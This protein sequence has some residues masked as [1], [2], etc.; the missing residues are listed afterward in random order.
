M[1]PVTR[2]SAKLHQC[3]TTPPRSR[4]LHIKRRAVF[5]FSRNRLRS[6]SSFFP[7]QTSVT[8]WVASAGLCTG[9]YPLAVSFIKRRRTMVSLLC[10]MTAAPS[11][12][13]TTFSFSV[14][15]AGT[16]HISIWAYALCIASG[17]SEMFAESTATHASLSFNR[18]VTSP[19]GYCGR[20]APHSRVLS[21]PP[22]GTTAA[23]PSV[24]ASSSPRAPPGN[25]R[26]SP[27]A[28]PGNTRSIAE[29]RAQR[30]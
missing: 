29:G 27:G 22:T 7:T 6:D 25:T 14:L 28:A 9:L 13:G 3:G 26:S 20:R 1:V 12:L 5:A 23:L 24:A 30:R 21:R 15:L 19:C 17:A 18:S 11:L 2:P 4:A 10:T 16:P 8:T